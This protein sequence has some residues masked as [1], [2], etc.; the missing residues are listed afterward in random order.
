[1]VLYWQADQKVAA[2]Y[3]VFTQLFDAAGKLVAQQ[4]NLPG[5]GQSPTD[6]WTTQTLV[7]DP[8]RLVLP[9]NAQAGA[10]HL[11]VGLYDAQGR[12]PLTLP[13]GTTADHLSF[14][15]NIGKN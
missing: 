2:S 8:Y 1:L 4:D 13:D 6:Q 10:Y 7:R 14:D 3:T 5:Q 12:R 11:L 9:A 15:L